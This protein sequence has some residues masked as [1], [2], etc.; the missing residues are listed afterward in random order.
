MEQDNR[1]LN[2]LNPSSHLIE[3]YK[4]LKF[5]IQNASMNQKF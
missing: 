4:K 2:I 1:S 5:N 3:A